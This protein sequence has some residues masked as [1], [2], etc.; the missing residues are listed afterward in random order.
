MTYVEPRLECM[1]FQKSTFQS[2]IDI[3]HNSMGF[4]NMK[5]T[6]SG[7]LSL[8]SLFTHECRPDDDDNDKHAT[9]DSRR[10]DA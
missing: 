6:E 1:Q 10:Y 8:P 7:N 4:R 5:Q 3:L 2:N 9:N